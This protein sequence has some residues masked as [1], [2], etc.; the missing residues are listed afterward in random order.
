M[1]SYKPYGRNPYG[2]NMNQCS[3]PSR[4]G[5]MRNNGNFNSGISDCGC[6]DSDKKMRTM[7][8]AM[9][10]VPVQSWG[11]LYDLETSLCQGTIFPDL[12]LKFCGARGKL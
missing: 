10:Y 11:E 8:L 2:R 4:P 3:N 6:S 5:Q 7:P 1:E 12:N 9:G